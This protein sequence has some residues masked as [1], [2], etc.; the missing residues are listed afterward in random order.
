MTSPSRFH[1]PCAVPTHFNHAYYS[2]NTADCK[3]RHEGWNSKSSPWF[4]KSRIPYS[5][6]QFFLSYFHDL[7]QLLNHRRKL[8]FQAD[9]KSC[10]YGDKVWEAV[11]SLRWINW[12]HDNRVFAEVLQP[13]NSEASFSLESLPVLALLLAMKLITRGSRLNCTTWKQQ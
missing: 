2:R 6:S 1:D 9:D 12:L 10:V 8:L 13:N 5:N 11:W 7:A 4:P 3:L